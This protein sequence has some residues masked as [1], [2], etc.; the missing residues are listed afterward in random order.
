MPLDFHKGDRVLFLRVCLSIF[1][2]RTRFAF[3]RCRST[4]I[5]SNEIFSSFCCSTQGVDLT[6]IQKGIS[7]V[8]FLGFEFQK[9]CILLGT[10]QSRCSFLGCQINAVYIINTDFY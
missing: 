6:Y 1:V 4:F 8:S 2:T 3:K 7:G 10:G 9:I 5:K